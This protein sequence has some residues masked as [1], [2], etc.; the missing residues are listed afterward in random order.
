MYSL[1]SLDLDRELDGAD[2]VVAHEWNDSALIKALNRHRRLN[3]GYK[4]LF[5]DTH[6]RSLTAP[7]E[8]EKY[9]LSNFD[10]VLAFGEVVRSIYIRNGWTDHAWVWHEAADVRIF[11][12]IEAGKN[13][14]VVWVG[15]WGDDERTLELN[16][17]LFQPVK[18]TGV[19]C[20]VYGVRYPSEALDK[21]NK[22]GISYGGWLPNYEVP[23][24]F[25]R[26]KL[27]VHIPRRPYVSLLHGI[28]TI[29]PFEALACGIPLI[30]S[31]WND[32]ENLFTQGKDYLL[33]RDGREMEQH[34]RMVLEDQ[35][36]GRELANHGLKT[37]FERH[38]CGHRVDQL[39]EICKEIGV[40]GIH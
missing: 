4:L 28:P 32:T 16:E 36:V 27:T 19:R 1:S 31:P 18:N 40:G 29:R 6:H 13:G 2:L 21:L 3:T 26:F 22:F 17:F 37:I 10:G 9:D 12:P 25:S 24:V 38:T 23:G 34:I 5:H 33:A 20:S 11:H 39:F 35:S 14:D 30:C 8:M 7:F 15:N